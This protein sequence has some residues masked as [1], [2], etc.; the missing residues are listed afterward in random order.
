MLTQNQKGYLETIP[1]HRI[2]HVAPFNPDV[3]KIAQNI[4]IEVESSM[5]NLNVTYLGSSKLGIAGENDIDLNVLAGNNYDDAILVLVK[6]FGQPAKVKPEKKIVQ[7]EFIKDGFP[8]EIFLTDFMTPSLQ[9]QFDAQEILE[10]NKELLKEYE[11][12]KIQANGLPY[13]EYL[14][15]KYEFWNRILGLDKNN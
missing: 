2:A 9:E 5:P 11:Q 6:M 15:R 10:K 4:I 12:I 1:D 7:W 8:V 14:K 13:K 3:Q